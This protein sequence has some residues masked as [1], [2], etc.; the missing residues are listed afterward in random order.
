MSHVEVD[1]G[2]D[3]GTRDTNYWYMEMGI[4]MDIT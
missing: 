4:R 1:V 2:V 3:V